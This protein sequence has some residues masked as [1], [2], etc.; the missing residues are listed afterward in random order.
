M[1]LIKEFSFQ[2]VDLHS[3][4]NTVEQIR[5]KLEGNNQQGFF[6]HSRKRGHWWAL[7]KVKNVWYELDSLSRSGPKRIVSQSPFEYYR[8]L[9]R[10]FSETDIS[11]FETN[12]VQVRAA[13]AAATAAQV[14]PQG[15]EPRGSG[16]GSSGS[17]QNDATGGERRRNS[18]TA[19]K[20]ETPAELRKA[21]QLELSWQVVLAQEMEMAVGLSHKSHQPHPLST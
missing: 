9:Q 11:L 7:A 19:E 1:L 3:E 16:S 12:I 2:Q 18:E 6:V 8:G 15:V 13:Q 14:E 5:A 10:E 20:I 17:E 4:T 21:I